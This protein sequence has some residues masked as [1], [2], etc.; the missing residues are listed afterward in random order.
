MC[1]SHARRVQILYKSILKLH[2]GLPAEIQELG[3]NY[4]RDEFKR[5]KN[6]KIVEEQQLIRLFM[7]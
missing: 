7:W 1:V 4:V 3:N 2:R 5:H 6:L